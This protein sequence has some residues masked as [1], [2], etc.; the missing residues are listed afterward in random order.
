LF[1]ALAPALEAANVPPVTAMRRSTLEDRVRT[2]L[3]IIGAVGAGMVIIGAALLALNDSIIG[4]FTALF[5]IIIG[6]ALIVP[7]ATQW[8]MTLAAPVLRRTVGMLGEIAARTVV[9]AI[10][11]TSV[12]IAALMV[13][14]SVTIGVSVMIA[15]FRATVVNWLDL[16]LVAD[17]YISAPNVGGTSN[18]TLSAA[19]KDDVAGV[20]GVGAVDTVRRVEVDS[21]DGPVSLVVSDSRTRRSASLYRF[22]NGDPEAIWNAVQNGA[23]V[24]SE[25]FAFRHNLPATGGTV[26]LRTEQ[27]EKTFNVVAI[28]YDY[29]SDQGAV[30]MSRTIY[31]QYWSDRGISG[32]G[33]YAAPGV[34]VPELADAIRV[35]LKDT[36]LQVQVNSELRKQALVVFDRTFAITDALRLLAVVVAFIGVLSALMAL[37]LER[38]R[39]LAT[40]Q[41]LGLTPPQ[42]WKL[43]LL[44]TGLMGATAGLLSLPTGFILA[45][46]L[47]YVINLRSFGWTIQMTLDPSVF[48]Q[49]M[50]V[51]IAAACLAALYPMRRLLRMEI[52]AALRQE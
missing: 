14:V 32:I 3:P 6:L 22:A 24:V 38:A 40:L 7:L 17:I 9:K 47:I 15:S 4:S 50:L 33:V 29:A 44:E 2:L 48:V 37:Q 27:G 12:A 13:A 34:N 21:P 51:S 19:I 30:L 11:R 20:T 16:T 39:E 10:S 5:F 52:A 25:P 8:L 23:V 31:E 45:L 49:A 43:T 1:A 46:V 28:Y 36:P 26:T 18:A 42:L 35:A 41:A